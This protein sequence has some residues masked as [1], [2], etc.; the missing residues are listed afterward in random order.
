MLR[1]VVDEELTGLADRLT[2][3]LAR[4]PADPMAPEWIVV[5]SAGV[6]R[7][8]RLH[9]ARHLGSSGPDSTDGVAANL[10]LIYPGSLV[11]RILVPGDDLDRDPWHVG[12]L[13]W[14]V[15]EVLTDHRDD[16]DLHTVSRVP[17][18][19][20]LWARARRI[21][22]HFDRYLTHRPQMVS[23]WEQGGDVDPWG[24]D[25]VDRMLWQP[26]LWRLVRARIGEPS[27]AE[28]LPVRLDEI[29][30]NGCPDEVPER[31][32]LF[33]L[34]TLPGGA[35]FLDLADALGT[36]REVHLFNHQPSA[37]F[38][39]AVRD[40]I[41][42]MGG[43]LLR[44][45]DDPTTDV[46]THP[47]L[48]SWARP[49]REALVLLGARTIELDSASKRAADAGS[50][51]TLLAQLQADIRA[52]REPGGGRPA[53]VADRSVR[54]HSCHGPSRQV[55]VLRDELLHLF[56]TN[57]DL[58][59]DDVVVLCPALDEY[60]P[61]IE[62][63]W[64]PSVADGES[65]IGSGAP[66]LAYRI[67]DRSLG[68]LVP[69]L[70]ALAS[71]VELLDSR[72]SD[73]AVLD[74][75]NL[76]PVRVRYGFDDEELSRLAT[77]VDEAN[78][79]WGLDGRHRARWG[80]PDNFEDASWSSA[81]DRLL[82]GI[83]ASD[84]PTAL[85]AGGVL[86]IGVEGDGIS[87]VG[88]F[89]ELIRRLGELAAQ[90]RQPRPLAEWVDLLRRIA[91]ELF[92]TDFYNSWQDEKLTAVFEQMIDEADTGSGP[93]S[94]LLDFAE[95]R[96]VLG[97]YLGTTA[98]RAVFFRGGIT[99]SSLTP[100]RGIPHRVVCL[101]GLDEYA[102]TT[103]PPAGDDLVSA[104]PAV[105]DRD[106]RGDARQA[107]LD[108]VL[109]AKSHLVMTRS[110]HSV[111]T[112]R[113]IPPAVAVAELHD[114]I[115]ATFHP[116]TRRAGIES[117]EVV[118]PRQAYDER[119]FIPA[120]VD[121]A[122]D[123][124]WSFDPMARNGARRRLAREPA[125]PFLAEPL[126]AEPPSIVEL[127]DL[128]EFLGAPVKYFLRRSLGIQL[129]PRPD[130]SGG[131]MVAPVTGS[132][133]LARTPE[134]ANLVLE[135]DGL[136]K[137]NVADDL[138]EHRRSGGDIESF[139]AREH[140][141]D[142]LPP[143]R[144]FRAALEEALAKVEPLI[145]CLEDFHVGRVQPV[146]HQIDVALSGGVRV[147]GSVRDDRGVDA[148]PVT[149]T[150][151]L[152][153]R[154]RE[155]SPWLDLVALAAQDPQTDWH[156]NLI[157]WA[158]TKAGF[159]RTDL[160]MRDGNPNVRRERAIAA[161]STLV[162]LFILGRREPLPLFP[163]LSVALATGRSDAQKTWHDRYNHNA[164]GDDEWVQLAFGALSFDELMALPCQPHDPDGDGDSRV[165]RYA[166][167]LWG[168]IEQ[169]MGPS[170]AH[171]E[172]RA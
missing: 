71:V 146:Q 60:A 25:L 118:H 73:A 142:D 132:S 114:V 92:A 57:P 84:D 116:D 145:G 45:S 33:G 98:G 28:S 112:N 65:A 5:P 164:D 93:S 37:A 15:L 169:S 62:A 49:A 149:V 109:S 51:P 140:A 23:A 100:L 158:K 29:R 12:R 147:V 48:R 115:A 64:G 43:S 126:D 47:L 78:T 168:T 69:L 89:A 82:L 83:V 40:H 161:L 122:V 110:G 150:P 4:P 104:S 91:R 74:V 136:D 53:D 163:K 10:D 42:D 80:V 144:L 17:E 27:P 81:L 131:K 137:W 54:I 67:S 160:H 97:R 55:E 143:G 94:V 34:A 151:S 36:H 50:Q 117:I 162:D 130:R 11:R 76:G 102:F 167:V 46:P 2:D 9:L 165:E 133:G 75:V 30:G 159:N 170:D 26:V 88:R 123:G 125:A 171:A 87:L 79:R 128:H 154:K 13:A 63:L 18:G 86:P 7:W 39:E 52:D 96:A 1:V 72:F 85:A 127:S 59:E 153:E 139:V 141:A 56:A 156:A 68:S 90:V 24:N 95:L 99:V 32:V 111:V 148:G 108:A 38:V 105:G 129:P 152:H 103:A 35:P 77:W 14:T 107:L 120:D 124:P 135:L 3:V 6:G 8:L 44:R 61:L 41:G 101:L 134:G 22:D 58:R 119:N 16:V 66:A 113:E 172:G 106:R 21:A 138:L 70:A 20:T 19:A 31:I 155:L 157:T 166:K 121:P